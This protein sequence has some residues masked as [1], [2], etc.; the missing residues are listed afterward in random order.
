MQD[1]KY[2][3]NIVTGYSK[4]KFP[5]FFNVVKSFD[6][7]DNSVP[8]LI[9]GLES[10]REKIEGFSIIKKS[11]SSGMLCWTYKKTERKYDFDRDTDAFYRKCLE[12]VLSDVE[13]RY[14]NIPSYRYSELKRIYSWVKG[15]TKKLCFLTR[16]SNFLF[17]YDTGRKMVFGL[18]LTLFEYMGVNR[19]KIVSLVGRNRN[20]IF[21]HNT[22]FMDG[23][24]RGVVGPTFCILC[25][26]L[27]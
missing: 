25:R 14:L 21:I 20:N 3:G 9:V 16:D 15:K 11:Y 18:S 2:I 13:Y 19:K 1:R 12:K 4:D 23:E 24:I 26:Y 7:V 8:T 10:A 27:E 22:G 6:E 5:K 17:I